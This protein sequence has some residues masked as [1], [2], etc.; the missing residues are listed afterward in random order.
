MEYW[1]RRKNL[2]YYKQVEKYLREN[3]PQTVDGRKPTLLDVGSGIQAGCKY[4]QRLQDL[5]D[6]EAIEMFDKG[7][8]LPDI[9]S[10]FHNY[11]TWEDKRQFDV[12]ICLQ[13]LEH[14]KEVEIAARK[15]LQQA[16]HLVVMSVPYRWQFGRCKSHI[17]DPVDE[18]KVRK[19]FRRRPDEQTIVDQRLIQMFRLEPWPNNS[20]TEQTE[21]LN[22]E[23]GSLS[24]SNVTD[25]ETLTSLTEESNSQNAQ[26]K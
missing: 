20:S 17:H 9:K 2:E 24:S 1:E 4:L 22:S 23:E 6:I 18:A 13:T 19:W 21:N 14:V 5:F 26:E 7:V 15:L 3:T 10:H 8:R 25:E 16:K 11:V 12:V